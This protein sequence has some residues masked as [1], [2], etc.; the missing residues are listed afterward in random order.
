MTFSIV[1]LIMNEAGCGVGCRKPIGFNILWVKAPLARVVTCEANPFKY[2]E[3]LADV[4]KNPERYLPMPRVTTPEATGLS[5][6]VGSAVT[7]LRSTNITMPVPVPRFL[8][9]LIT[10]KMGWKIENL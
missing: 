9:K 10:N 5:C 7:Q 1:A 6:K 8:I 4:Q 2:N 3:E